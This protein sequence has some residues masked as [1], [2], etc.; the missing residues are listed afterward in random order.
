LK[1]EEGKAMFTEKAQRIINLAKS[2]SV[3][4]NLQT[5]NLEAFTNAVQNDSEA[6]VLLAECLELS[7]GE[8]HFEIS[9]SLLS[10]EALEKLPLDKTVKTILACVKDLSEEVPDT[11][12]PGLIDLR[13]IVCALAMSAEACSLIKATPITRKDA[14]A[15]LSA[16]YQRDRRSPSLEELTE[17]LRQL[18]NELLE[19]VFGQDHAVHAFVEGL[20]NA[21]V[22]ATADEKRKVP[23]AV[24]VFA[25][26]PGVGK[27]FLAELGASYLDRP[28]KR[29][30]MSAYSGHQQNEALVGMAKS[31]HGAHPGTLTEFVSKNPNAVL[32]FDEIEKSHSNTI[33]LFLQIL[34]AG[35]LEDKYHERNESFRDTIIIFTTNA[36]RKLYDRP[37]MIG[38][39]RANAAFHRK[40]ILDALETEQDPLTRQPYFPAAICSRL[41]TGYPILF[42]HLGVNELERVVKAELERQSR[43][44]ERQYYKSISFDE[45]LAISLVLR[46]GARTDAR[47]CK[48]QTETFVKTEVFKLCQ[49]FKTSRLEEVIQ[50]IGRIHFA[51]DKKSTSLEPEIR[52]LF[53]SQEKPRILLLADKDLSDLYKEF[54]PAIDWR[55]A[56]LPEEALEIL[57]EE[58]IDMVL[59]DLWVGRE[60][61]GEMMTIRQFDHI[62]VAAK[63]LSRGQ[64]L[65]RKIRERLS[66]LPVYLLSLT[67]EEDQ[68]QQDGSVDE[69]LFMACVRGG[70]A[71]GIVSS[72]FIDGM[73]KNWKQN[74]DRLAKHLLEICKCL[75]REKMAAKMGQE[76]KVLSFDTAPRLDDSKGEV[77]IR[78][79]NLRLSRA[80]AAADAA[81]VLDEVER[82]QTRFD[83]V[84]GANS[85]KEELRFFVDYLKNPKRFA[86]LGLKPPKGVLLYGPPGTGKT[87]LAR[88]MAGE[89]NVA[90]IPATASNFVT[91]WQGS[92]PQNIRDL[93]ERARRYAPAIVFIDE[94]DAIGKVRTGSPG[95]GQATE[96]TLNALLTEMDGF[97]SPSAERPVFLLAATNFK[98]AS[99]EQD[100]P[101]RSARTLDPALVRR[102]SRT[103]LVDLP[104]TAARKQYLQIRLSKGKKVKIS[105][106]AVELLAEKSIGMSIADLETVIETASRKAVQKDSELTDEILLEAMDTSR[107]GEAKEWSPEFLES[108]ARH[109]AG[110]T[111]MYWLAG[112]MSPEVS[113][114]ARSDHGGGMRRCEAEIKRESLTRDELLGRIRT[115]LGGRAAEI[116]YYGNQKGLTTGAAGDLENATSLARQM[117]CCYG[118]DNEFGI[119]ATPEL[120]KHAQAIGSPTYQ[121]VNEAA[122]KI[123]K[124]EMDKTLKLL[125][126]NR[127]HVDAVVKVLLEKNR[128]LRSD[129]ESILPDKGE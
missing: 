31:F 82:P 71:R 100:S 77:T 38:V 42:N 48:A 62:P 22:V 74:R 37:N 111:I 12:H 15:K 96:N 84:I 103:I 102:F 17:R 1:F 66:N 39:H 80:V 63:E 92:G 89:S 76:R 128:I 2:Y 108:T 107:E 3:L 69:E 8:R 87:M 16:W 53:E 40:T 70:G 21:E 124:E 36:G 106:S 115:C 26:P 7:L 41:A 110:H 83:D 94:L 52:V 58:E 54:I 4:H 24:F 99:E 29:F 95:G 98:I 73:V 112:W 78:L 97:I 33:Q 126:K 93:F 86:A 64:E 9:E 18:R 46:E 59:L 101:E 129:L 120:F 30:D 10:H 50:K 79:R 27:T 85:A 118:M 117:I 44:F 91:I 5:L 23:K 11:V 19:K 35:T 121:Q 14:V 43:L 109:E 47:T 45:L 55:T 6:R 81:E 56:T 61:V 75:Y 123:L 113:I 72:G 88:A 49:L 114:I 90:F 119:L 104:D 105:N 67:D 116:L 127:K 57:A 125:E 20:F 51:M 68:E 65:L 34:D 60:A 28:F 32:L 25:G 13:H 122:N